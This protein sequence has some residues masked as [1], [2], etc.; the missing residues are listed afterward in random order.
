MGSGKKKHVLVCPL[1][2]GI[3]HATRCIPL[4]SS[5]LSQGANVTLAT[6][7]N[8]LALLHNEFPG[9]ATIEFPGFSPEYPAN[10]NMLLNMVRLIPS[11]LW[12]VVSEHRRL[13]RIIHEKQVDIVI[14]DNR[15]GVW[16]SKVKSILIT[17]Q[18]F[19]RSPKGWS[20]MNYILLLVNRLFISQFDECWI[21]DF[22]GKENLSGELSHLKPAPKNCH[23]IG[24][25]SRLKAGYDFQ[26]KKEGILVL[27]S[28][29]EPQREMLEDIITRQL[30]ELDMEAL[31]VC[32]KAFSVPLTTRKSKL[33]ILNYATSDQINEYI[34]NFPW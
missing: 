13:A 28:G 33:T 4:I 11:F 17:H 19:I 30:E 29:P 26:G 16:N 31:I 7:G 18:L 3:G 20:W 24:P 8:S 5:I 14:S 25:L 6:S 22:P 15:Y 2:W 34:N 23:F 12:N 9:L 21:P 27:L 32:G 1:N 10:G